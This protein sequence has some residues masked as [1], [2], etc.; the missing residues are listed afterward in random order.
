MAHIR[1]YD[2]QRKRKGKT[3]RVY[4]VVWREPVRDK[5]GLPTAKTRA[6]QENYPTREAAEA[7]RDELNAARHTTGISALAEQR[8]AGDLPFGHYARAWLDAQRVKVASGR[9][10]AATIDGYAARLAVYVLPEFGGNAIAAITPRDCEQFLAALVGRGLTPATLKH[11]WSVLRNVFVY[12]LRH[13][14]ITANPVDGVDFSVSS[15][16]R[17]NRRHHPLTAEQVAAVANSIGERHPVYELMTYFA[18]YTGLRAEEL[19]GLEVGDLVFAPGPSCTVHVRRAKKRQAGE[20]T[21]DTLKS[22]RSRRDVPLPPWLATKLVDYLA[23]THPRGTEALA[24]LW[25]N[26]ALGG[27]RRRGCRAAAPLDFTEPCD[28]GT[29]YKNLLK[30]AFEAVGLP[31]SRPA[32]DDT[33]AV[34]GVRLHDLRH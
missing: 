6:R 2:T 28:M 17:R 24:P 31:A 8:K 16:Q 7:R 29:Y 4:R 1:S 20:W 5:F 13:K 9:V 34:E 23:N 11:H 26:R 22:A 21:T 27:A 19:A 15:A 14:A 18:A 32:T 30:P 25:P 12:A 33:P 10:K 3:V